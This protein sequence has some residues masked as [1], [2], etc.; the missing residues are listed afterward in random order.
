VKKMRRAKARQGSGP[1]PE[2]VELLGQFLRE[3]APKSGAPFFK[4][5]VAASEAGKDVAREALRDIHCLR[6]DAARR[7]ATEPARV[8]P[9]RSASRKRT[10][11]AK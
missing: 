1:D 10:R 7:S 5:V 6:Q 8:V 9:V 11:R 3:C 2:W 4:L